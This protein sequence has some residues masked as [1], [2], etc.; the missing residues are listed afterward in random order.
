[1][2]EV[3]V[4]VLEDGCEYAIMDTISIDG[5]KYIYLS[6]VEN[7]QAL[8]IRKLSS[9]EKDILGLKDETEFKMA[10][11]AYVTKYKSILTEK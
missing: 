5:V 6:Q 9:D 2:I 4:V 7:A 3:E 8:C 1:M 11:H 10:L